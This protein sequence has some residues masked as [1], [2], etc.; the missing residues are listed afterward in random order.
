MPIFD[1][2]LWPEVE[3]RIEADFGTLDLD[4]RVEWVKECLEKRNHMTVFRLDGSD[5]SKD[6]DLAIL[7]ALLKGLFILSHFLSNLILCSE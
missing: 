2:A 4:R 3:K 1:N 6:I 7:Q 5:S